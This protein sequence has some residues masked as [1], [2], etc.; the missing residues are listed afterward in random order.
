MDS[1]TLCKLN[2]C[3]NYENK[4]YRNCKNFFKTFFFQT[5]HGFAWH[6][7]RIHGFEPSGLK[8]KE[9]KYMCE[10]CSMCFSHSKYLARHI[11]GVHKKIKEKRNKFFQKDCPH[12]KKIFHKRSRLV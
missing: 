7:Q 4:H 9:K 5:E 12:C 3:C 1:L 10:Q 2:W 8:L 11:D 6:C